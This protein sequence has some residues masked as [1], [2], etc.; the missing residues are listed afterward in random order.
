MRISS[1]YALNEARGKRLAAVHVTNL[2]RGEDW[3]LVQ[4][5][6]FQHPIA[7]QIEKALH[8]GRSAIVETGDG[9]IFLNA[10]RPPPVIVVIGAVHISQSLAKIA[11]LTDFDV[12]II[13]PRTAFATAERFKDIDLVA[14]WPLD[15]LR[16]RPLDRYTA[17][18]AVTHDPKIDDRPIMQAL[19]A[20]CFYVGALGS[21]KTH[22]TRLERLR[23]QGLDDV[24]LSRIHAPIGLDI[25]AVSPAEI[26]VAILAEIIQAARMPRWAAGEAS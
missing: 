15:A 18:V 26:A 22:A 4:G 6:Q 2:S 11:K 9:E 14:D 19:A 24:D 8:S 1:L 17:L 3:V 23:A 13:D 25:G 12:R 16:D 7:T 10:Q 5:Q 20:G 21:R